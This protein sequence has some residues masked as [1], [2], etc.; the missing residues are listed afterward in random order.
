MVLLAGGQGSRLGFDGPKGMFD[1]GLP[2][3]RSLFQMLAE[4]FLKAQMNAHSLTPGSEQREDGSSVPVI[5][6][7]TQKCRMFI[8]TN[9]ENHL[10][11]VRFFKDNCYF[12]G[13]ESSFVFFSQDML[14]AL[15]HDGK[16]MMN[17]NHSLKLAPN[18]N[19][20][21]IETLKTN[22]SVQLAVS[23]YEYIQIVSVDN[24]MNKVLDP[25]QI[26]FTHKNGLQSSLKAVTKRSADEKVGVICKKNGKYNI[27]DYG[28][29]PAHMATERDAEGELRFDLGHILVCLIRNDLMMKIV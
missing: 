5:P 23:G 8:M 15:D 10:Q 3:H 20:A 12:G 19:G 7:E 14:P 22:S 25:V 29:L 2:S 13:Q 26:G 24:V 1:I 28:E 21:L 6:A 18:G 17:S 9:C 27:V 16:I 4:R 11:T